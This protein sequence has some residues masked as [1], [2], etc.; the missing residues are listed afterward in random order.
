MIQCRRYIGYIIIPYF[1]RFISSWILLLWSANLPV[2]E[3]RIEWSELFVFSFISH[4]YFRQLILVS[5]PRMMRIKIL[6][7][8]QIN[9]T[10]SS[11]RIYE[12]FI[13]ELDCRS[14]CDKGPLLLL[15]SHY[16]G[17]QCTIWVWNQ[18]L[19]YRKRRM[20]SDSQRLISIGH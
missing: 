5:R 15:I 17:I 7:N 2:M 14:D 20:K 6:Q 13:L 19:L 4:L 3:R 1:S 18:P 11:K 10:R 12:N 16:L 8:M 9:E